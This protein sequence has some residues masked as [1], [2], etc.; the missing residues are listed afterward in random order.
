MA[1][2]R[3]VAVL[4]TMDTKGDECEFLRQE[5]EKLGGRAMLIDIGVIGTTK[6]EV[7][8]EK[9]LVAAEGGSS[10][11]EL[12]EDPSRQEA[13]K[14]MVAGSISLLRRLIEEE[15]IGS[16]IGLGGTQGTDAGCRIM[17]ELP[18]GF[19][20]LMVSTMASGDTSG[21]VGIKDITMMFSVSDI[22]GLNPFS[23]RILANAAG[24][25]YGMALVPHSIEFTSDKPLIGISNL[26]VL[27]RGTM[28]A[29][30]L[31]SD[32]GYESIV[33]HAVGSGGKAMEQMMKEGIIKAVFDYGLGEIPDACFEGI[34]A[35]D[36]ER[37][38]VA[39][40]LGLP[41][42]I[43]PGGVDHLGVLL[44]E[45]NV[46]PDRYKDRQYDFH[47]PVI[48]VPRCSKEELRT[49]MESIADRLQ[50]SKSKTV[51]MLPKKGVSS[52]GVPGGVLHNEEG[53]LAFHE[54]VRELLPKQIEL[55]E[56]DNNA[57]DEAFVEKAVDTLI[58]LIESGVPAEASRI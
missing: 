13:T 41:Q 46:V 11:E 34:R 31:L 14:A 26:G 52:Y 33:F 18:Y 22:L 23:R 37:L 4:A 44:S 7:D 43:V 50:H 32:R 38:T 27:T 45:A 17:Q 21:F 28:K 47:N 53:D 48:F 56:M 15:K 58:A 25:A 16:L 9:E 29:I 55:I 10:M 30:K 39:G 42:V 5:I 1:L 51:F 54:D 8:I 36:D 57:E 20:K 3:C 19:P 12:L 6:I 35:C 24:A 40:K 49:V 2:D